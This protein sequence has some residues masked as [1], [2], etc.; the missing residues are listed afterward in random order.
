MN[1]VQLIVNATLTIL[2][3][4]VIGAVW[5][6]FRVLAQNLSE[7][8]RAALEQFARMATQYVEQEQ[9]NALD[10]K[11]LAVAYCEDLFEEFKRP[12]KPSRS[13]IEIAVGSAMF[14][15]SKQRAEPAE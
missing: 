14:E 4:V 11:E 3:P 7:Y 2:L 5:W 6:L 12:R 8:R 15:A 10:K 9:G 1:P 13:A